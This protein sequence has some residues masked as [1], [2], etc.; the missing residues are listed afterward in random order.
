MWVQVQSITP[1]VGGFTAEV[2]GEI[3]TSFR[4]VVAGRQGEPVVIG[5]SQPKIAM[6]TG[7]DENAEYTIS[8]EYWQ[9]P[10][11]ASATYG[12]A[13]TL[14]AI[15]NVKQ[16]G[17]DPAAIEDLRIR[18]SAYCATL[19]N[20]VEVLAGIKKVFNDWGTAQK[21]GAVE[22]IQQRS[23]DAIRKLGTSTTIKSEGVIEK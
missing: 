9:G 21:A 8:Y 18:L 22:Q 16:W 7:L 10:A 4:L 19:S 1:T 15:D 5:K 14:G 20:G 17:N 13:R 23:E 12:R 2:N 3:G 11:V 6:I